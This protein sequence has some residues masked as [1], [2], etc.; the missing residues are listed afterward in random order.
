MEEVSSILPFLL[1]GGFSQTEIV[2]YLKAKQE[3]AREVIVELTQEEDEKVSVNVKKAAT[4]EQTMSASIAEDSSSEES[5]LTNLS[6]AQNNVVIPQVSNEILAMVNIKL[7]KMS[8]IARYEAMTLSR[9]KSQALE[10]EKMHEVLENIAN[11][12]SVARASERE[13]YEKL[14]EKLLEENKKDNITARIIL[15]AANGMLASSANITPSQTKAV[16]SQIANPSLVTSSSD[17]ERFS[18]LHDQLTKASQQGNPLATTL[19][20]VKETVSEAE[21]ERLNRQLNEE[22]TKGETFAASILSNIVPP[23]SL[24]T[25]NRVQTVN[26]EDYEAVKQMWKENYKNLEVPPDLASNRSEWINND[27]SKTEDITNKLSSTDQDEVSKGMEEVSSILPFLLV[28]GF[29]QTEIVAY[30]KAKQEAAR[31]T[32]AVIAREDEDKVLVGGSKGAEVQR[33]VGAVMDGDGSDTYSSSFQENNTTQVQGSSQILKIA[34][35]QIPKLIDIVQYEV[36]NLTKDKTESERMEKIHSVLEKIANPGSSPVKLEREQYEKLRARLAEESV[37]GNFTAD[38]ILSAV[39]QLTEITGEINASLTQIKTVLQLIANPS[40]VPSDDDRTYYTRLHEYLEK[41]A[42][43]R[44]N[45]LAQKILSVNE[46]TKTSDI[47]SIKEELATAKQE[48]NPVLPQ[49]TTAVNDFAR[50][51]KLRAVLSQIISPSTHLA[52]P[53]R[54]SF[55]KLHDSLNSASK[56]GNKLAA[57][58]LSVNEETSDSVL[59]QIGQDLTE[60]GQKGEPVAASI[61]SQVSGNLSLST[62]N[63]LQQVTPEEYQQTKQLWEKAYKQYFVPSGFTEDIK[64]RTE[65]IN[66]DVSDIEETINLLESTDAEKKNNGIKKVSSILPFLLL[67]GFSLNETISY[68]KTKDEAAKNVLTEIEQEEN[69]SVELPVKK[70]EKLNIKAR[71]EE[72]QE[73]EKKK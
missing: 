23:F 41:E 49:L 31:E 37:G 61:L 38:A 15:A 57:S 50:L 65:W 28:G 16:L 10:I 60:A 3:A 62:T 72:V 6:S 45:E 44:N 24:P 21:I 46:T 17:K 67:G 48:G 33:S 7:P 63:R 36:R 18:N 11:P 35:L 14:R 53:D 34:N 5:D 47:Q 43:E 25:T 22:K 4:A 59:K 8:D 58:L 27:I 68:L 1:V 73:E 52:P 55:T 66:Q 64:G 29:S 2:A 54:V 40:T 71:S 39:W 70:D 69:K 30:L 26:K 42:G 20:S 32:L 12:S 9:D 19:L 13:H 51:K 56:N